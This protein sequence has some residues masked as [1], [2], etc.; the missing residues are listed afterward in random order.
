MIK[1]ERKTEIGRIPVRIIAIEVFEIC[2]GGPEIGCCHGDNQCIVNRMHG[3]IRILK[4]VS[5][6]EGVHEHEDLKEGGGKDKRD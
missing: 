2:H 6:E 4:L 5:L 1:V 3:V